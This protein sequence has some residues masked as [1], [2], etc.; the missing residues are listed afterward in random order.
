MTAI[1]RE[2]FGHEALA[3]A[4]EPETPFLGTA[5]VSE[6]WQQREHPAD[7]AS[8]GE[9]SWA[10]Q[11]ETPFLTEYQGEAPVNLEATAFGETLL[12]LRDQQF[13]DAFSSLALQTAAQ[14]EEFAAAGG[15]V[16]AE[17]LIG[18]W[19]D[20]L[21]R[22]MEALFERTADAASRQT[23]D[24]MSENEIDTFLESF[25]PQPGAVAPEFEA[26]FQQ[27]FGKIGRII[28]AGV[29][30]AKKGIAAVGRIL[31]I[32]AIL[33]PLGKLIRPLLNRVIR[34]ALNRLPPAL[35]SAATML[36]RRL[37]ILRETGEFETETPFAASENTEAMAF[38]FDVSVANLMFA[39]DETEM[40]LLTTEVEGEESAS[41]ILP[42]EANAAAELDAARERFVSQF[43]QLQTDENPA[44]AIQQFVP[45]ILPALRVALTVVGRQRVVNFLARLL[46]RLISRFVGPQAATT[47]SRALVD[48]GLRLIS[49]EAEA[50]AA[51]NEAARVVAAT[52]EDTMR[53]LAETHLEQFDQ[54][55]ESPEQQRVLETLATEAFFQSAIAHIP[56]RLLDSRR[57]EERETMPEMAGEAGVWAYR[58]RP[59]YKKYTR[60]FEITLTPQAAARIRSFGTATLANFLRARGIR[61]PLKVRVH[62]YEAIPGTVLSRIALLER[63]VPGLGSRAEAAWSQIHP[64]TTEAAG[65]LLNE[66]GLGRDVASRFLETRHRVGVGQRFYYLELPRSPGQRQTS[67]CL[68]RMGE[69]NLAVDLRSQSRQIRVL[70]YFSD[71]E[72]Q[73]IVAARPNGGPMIALNLV[74]TLWSALRETA[75]EPTRHVRTYLEISGELGGEES[76]GAVKGKAIEL[77]LLVLQYFGERLL[78]YLK[79]AII[80]CLNNRLTEFKIAQDNKACGVTLVF[81][82]EIS[83]LLAAALLAPILPVVGGPAAIAL[84]LMLKPPSVSIVAGFRGA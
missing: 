28:K 44:P 54:I 58:P 15:E 84:A 13:D 76:V 33:R 66:P 16:A 67:S 79:T 34:F 38:E 18:E 8:F 26:F 22:E 50:E 83:P 31:P 6:S 7:A 71:A 43:A 4:Y 2:Q 47:L 77:S 21:R 37:G 42:S 39:R 69:I 70:W 14:A 27:F 81:I 55:D 49:L 9:Q 20:P 40:N 68:P 19:L 3:E 5:F 74:K 30:L 75:K 72:A 29:K 56:A 78:S 53:R 36:G 11:V 80:D 73:R 51:P 61:P 10:P 60:I 65:L 82:F 17:Q 24:T 23:L 59:R 35:R 41:G 12:E 64:L 45:F 52:L 63:R 62:L 48:V 25:S 46:A 32:G 1:L 57:L